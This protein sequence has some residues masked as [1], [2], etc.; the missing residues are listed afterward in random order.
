[1]THRSRSDVPPHVLVVDDD[2]H[3]GE[4]LSI[5]LESRGYRV[6]FEATASAGL[7]RLGH[8]KIDAMILDLRLQDADGLD[9]L[10]RAQDRSPDVPVIILTA[11][12]TIETAVLAMQRGAYG[13]LTKPFEDHEL[14][15]KLAHAVERSA[16]KREVAGLRSAMGANDER[17]MVGVSAAIGRVR[18]VIARIAP[19]E[20]TVLITGESGTGKE[21]AAR[22]LHALSPRAKERFLGVNCGALPPELL[23][24]ELFGHIKGAF[25]G[26]T[27][28]REGLFGAARGGTLFLDEIGEASPAVQVKLLRAI[29][30]RRFTKVGATRE[31][32]SDVRLI[33]ATNRDLRVEVSEKRFREDLFYRLRVVPL[34][35]PPLRER[36]EDIL[37]LSELFLERAASRHGLRV[38]RLSRDALEVMLAYPWPGNVRELRH[39]LEAAVLLAGTDELR[40]AHLPHLSSIAS[41]LAPVSVPT[42]VPPSPGP[43]LPPPDQPLPTL[44]DARDAFERAYL[45][46]AL[47]RC[48]GNVAAAARAAGRNRSDFYDL[49]RRHQ[50]SPA[51]FK[52]DA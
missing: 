29:E 12:G 43:L 49:L 39:E 27:Q 9:V 16:L 47:R 36:R 46:E 50:I 37:V 3:L 48:T 33:A 51:E 30:E 23:E 11:H 34:T 21:I 6:T 7:E 52:E 17:H 22:A 38:P 14:M 45:V 25:T 19:T 13:F 15:Q 35:M 2:V 4:L 44:K 8:E 28:D 41:S 24:S 31:E 20:A 32:E 42:P 1:M 5:R 18:D 26:A 40:A 10:A